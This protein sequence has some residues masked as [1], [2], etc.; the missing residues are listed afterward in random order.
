MKKHLIKNGLTFVV[1]VLFISISIT[2]SIAADNPIKSS[3]PVFI[4][5]WFYVG[6]NGTGNYTNI[7]DAVDN[8]SDGDTVFVYDDSSPYYENVFVNKSLTLKGEDKNTTIV[9]GVGD[10]G[11]NITINN[12]IINDFMIK[13]CTFGIGLLYNIFE[14]SNITISNNTIYDCG[15]GVLLVNSTKT[16]I[17]SNTIFDN[18]GSSIFIQKCNNSDVL[19]NIFYNNL[20]NGI[21]IKR[22]SNCSIYSNDIYSNLDLGISIIDS[23][24]YNSF[25]RN[26]INNNSDKGVY[27][28]ESSSNNSFCHNNFIN[29]TKNA[30]DC[31]DNLWGRYPPGGNYWSDYNGKDNYYGYDQD[32]TGSDGIGDTPYNISQQKLSNEIN[33]D[34]YPLMYPYGWPFQPIYLGFGEFSFRKTI[35]G[36]GF[37][38]GGVISGKYLYVNSSLDELPLK[39]VF[40]F[41]VEMN[42]TT[43][44]HFALSPLIALGLQIL[45]YSD[46]SWNALKLKHQGYWIW[47]ENVTH[48]IIIHPKDFKKGDEL[49]LYV[50]ISSIPVPFL[51]SPGNTKSWEYILRIIYNIPVINKLLLHKWALPFLAPYNMMFDEPVPAIVIRFQ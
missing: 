25:S 20:Q 34:K 14:V 44:F 31:G 21:T 29:N 4:G 28:D 5:N 42:Y 22:S 50:N 12:T 15:H 10:V 24:Q 18:F 48:E 23:S 40:Y 26:N 7:Q 39:I 43:L 27:V 13:N 47:N 46:Y 36:Y 33:R 38:G 45:N 32:I 11:F 49:R 1:I 35:G 8:A 19:N 37:S 6:G 30:C 16:Y 51:N 41:T 9:D 17:L 3:M 2:H